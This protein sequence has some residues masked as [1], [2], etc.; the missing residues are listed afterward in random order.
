[1]TMSKIGY[2]YEVQESQWGKRHQNSVEHLATLATQKQC[3]KAQEIGLNALH[4]DTVGGLVSALGV[5]L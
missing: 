5:S 3:D 1:M 4:F 2:I